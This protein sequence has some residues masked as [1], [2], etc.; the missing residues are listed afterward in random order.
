MLCIAAGVLTLPSVVREEPPIYDSRGRLVHPG[1]RGISLTFVR[2]GVVPP[3]AQQEALAR[4]RFTGLPDEVDPLTQI[5]W[6]DTDLAAE[7]NGWSDQ[8]RSEVEDRLRSWPDQTSFI[9]VAKPHVA[10][11]W[12]RY[13]AIVVKGRRDISH[14]VEQILATI[15]ATGVDPAAVLAYER[16]EL[17]RP[18]VVAA[19]EGKIAEAAAEVDSEE[20]V[21]A[22]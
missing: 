9:I 15:D 5:C 14:V 21:I 8:E 18:E 16:Q 13:D 2:G 11:P 3:H 20:P 12:P 4:L 1:H 19:L 10:A 22:A 7:Q 17:N 6:L